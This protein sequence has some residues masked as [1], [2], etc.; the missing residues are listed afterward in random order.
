ML[1]FGGSGFRA[2]TVS[3]FVPVMPWSSQSAVLLTV[4]SGESRKYNM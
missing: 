1:G 2:I 4:I 3:A